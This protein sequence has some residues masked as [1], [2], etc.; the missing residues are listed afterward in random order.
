MSGHSKWST[1]KRKK[2]AADAR[3]GKIFTKI[4]KE[5]TVAARLGGGDPSGNSR[6]RTAIAVARA[7]NMP[8]ENIERAIKKGTGELEGAAFEEVNYEGYGPGGSAILVETMTDNKN[9]TVSE[10]RRLFIKNNG[11]MAEAGSVSWIFNKKGLISLNKKTAS[12]D[13]VM[14]IALESG[15]EDVCNE[16]TTCD[17]LTAPEDF[18]EVK[19]AIIE[20]G[21]EI[22]LAEISMIPIS[23]VKIE[24]KN[25]EQM[26]R[27]MEALEDNEDI[28]K[29][30]A[31]FDISEEEM[32]RLMII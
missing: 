20:A 30:Y 7:E 29:V 17:V 18:E 2:G 9:R 6:L 26:L 3:R 28:Q 16:E 14:E 11:S 25:A 10:I 13:K 1:I 12:E 23:T 31:N 24:G 4:I 27:L 19:R 5:I 21:L 22:E 32:E 8:K 15:A